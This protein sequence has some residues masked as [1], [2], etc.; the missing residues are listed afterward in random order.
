[1]TIAP[2]FDTV[3]VANR[4]EIAVRVIR[5]LRAL[6]IRSVAVY[7]DADADARHVARGR[8]R[9]AASG[10]PPARRATSTSTRSSRPRARTGAQAVHPGYGFLAENA[11]F[12]AALRRRPGIVFVGPPVDGDRGDGRQDPRQADGVGGRRPGRARLARRRARPTP[13]LVAAAARGRLPGAGQ[14]VGG[15]RRQGHARRAPS[16]PS[17]ADALASGPPRGARR[18]SATTRCSSSGSSRPRGTSRSRCSPTRTATCPPRRARVLACSAATRRSSRRRR[19]RCSTP[20]TAR[21]RSAPPPCDGRAQ[22][23]LHRRGHGR[24]HRRRPTGPTSSSSW[25]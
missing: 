17:C 25:R 10:P 24:V 18:R 23:R 22:R 3:L 4:G 1:M 12:A 15:R 16:R 14:A 19:R 11:A 7:S 9:G 5:T 20:A 2:M 6:G 13:T 21:A 8:R